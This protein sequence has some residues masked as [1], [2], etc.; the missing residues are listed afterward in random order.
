MSVLE[1]L[2]AAKLT[3]PWTASVMLVSNKPTKSSLTPNRKRLLE[4]MQRLGFGSIEELYVLDGDPVMDPP[5]RIVRDIKLGGENGPRPE[6]E[7]D[8]FALKKKVI[9]FFKELDEL[10]N[11]TVDRIEIRHGLPFRMSIKQLVPA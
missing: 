7:V 4:L 1:V 10:Q 8:D 3:S 2:A 6:L 5:P 11:G 9:E